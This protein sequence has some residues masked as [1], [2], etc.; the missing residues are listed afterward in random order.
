MPNSNPTVIGAIPNQTATED[1]FY[2]LNISGYFT[3]SDPGDSLTYSATGL[4][5]GLTINSTTGV[6]SGTPTNT[7]VGT[8]TITIFANDKN[9]GSTSTSFNLLVNNTNDA[10]TVVTAI[11]DQ[12]ATEDSV[13]SFN[14]STYFSDVDANDTL[15]YSATGLPDG[16][17]IN[18][19]SGVIS[20]TP[21]NDAVG[22]R[23]ISIT[24]T[25]TSGSKATTNFK[26][27]VANTND[28]PTATTIANRNAT[29]DTFFSMNVSSGFVDI[30][31]GDTLTY[32]AS[33][34]PDGLTIN[35][36]TGVISG[37]PTNNAVG[38]RN[39]TVT[40]TDSSGK[41]AS[42]SFYINIANT[43]DAPT[44]AEAIA[45]QTA[46]EDQSFSLNV[47]NN[48]A[49]MDIGDT[50]TFS[51]TGLPDGLSINT[52]TG[53]ISGSPTNAA[54][55]IRN[56]SVTATDISGS[57]VSTSFK[58]TVAN[59][60]DAPTVT[61]IANQNA[62]E[63]AFFSMN[64]SSYFADIDAGDTLT[65][66]ATGLP[67][68]V[69]INPT[70]GVISGNPTNASV[71]TRNVTVTATDTSGNNANSSFNIIVA[72][73]NDAPTVVAPIADQTA[74]EDAPFSL[75]TSLYF[76]DIDGIDTLT[77]S[78]T[79]LPSG[80][81]IDT[82]TGQISGNALNSAVGS[83]NVTVTINDG[84]GG[85]ASNT[86]KL[87][88]TNTNDAP[89]AASTLP[90][91]TAT[92]D[93][94]FSTNVSS[95]FSDPDVG[96]TLSFYATNLPKGLSINNAT[97]VI[98]GFPTNEAVGNTTVTIT[99]SDG[100]GGTVSNSFV[101]TVANT[102]DAPVV[103]LPIGDRS[104][105]E[106]SP[107]T[108]D[109]SSNFA[110]PDI[111][112]T[113]TYTATGLPGGLSIASATGIISGTPTNSSVGTTAV[114]VTANDGKGGT[115]S[116]AFNL[117]VVN[118]ND[119]PTLVSAI[120]DAS[121]TEDAPFIYSVSNHF[122]DPDVGDTLT[123]F[124]TGLPSGL[125]LDSATGL[126]SGAPT[127]AAVG[128]NTI[129]IIAS[130]SKGGMTSG[131]F[132]LTVANTNDGPVVAI[133]IGDRSTAEDATFTLDVS[134]AFSDPDAGDTLT[135]A[136]TGLPDGLAIN[137]STGIISGTPTNTAVGAN[138]ITVTANDGKGGSV[139]TS[140]TLTVTN[141]NDAPIL[142]VAIA[143]Q[144][145]TED[146][147][148]TYSVSSHFADIDQGDTLSFFAKGLPNGLTLDSVTGLISGTPTN[149]AV[150]THTISL[151]ASDSK[152][153]TATDSFDLVVANTND[154]PIVV[155][156][157]ADR[158]AIEDVA[159]NLN[160]SANFSDPDLGDT[161]TYS[162][163]GLPAG[164]TIDSTTGLISGTPNN[165]AVGANA[166][167]V[168]ASD[169]NGSTVNSDFTL[170]VTNVNDD[171]I[172]TTPLTNQSTVV[173]VPYSLNVSS[174]FGDLDM[175]NT[176]TYF[177]TG[178]PTGLSIDGDT[179]V[180]SGN[181]ANV[182]TSSITITANDGNGGTI[183]AVFDLTVASNTAPTV[184]VAIADQT[185][186]AQASYSL[187]LNSGTFKEVDPGDA[188][189]L[190]ASL[191][192]GNGLPGWLSFNPGTRTFSGIP[193]VGDVG[194]LGIRVTATDR[195]GV[196]VSDVFNLTVN[197]PPT[198]STPTTPTPAIPSTPGI[199]NPGTPG[200]PSGKT[201]TGTKK[202]DRLLGSSGDDVLIGLAGNDSLLAQEGNDMVYGGGGNDYINGGTGVDTLFGGVGNDKLKG[203]L[204]RDIFVL[205]KGNGKDTFVDFN[206]KSDRLGLSRGLSFK[207]LT[208]TQSGRFASISLGADQIAF[209]EGVQAN[210]LTAA[211][212]VKV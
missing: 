70:T 208:I 128:V 88:V 43:N 68:G 61:S 150:G 108:L 171:P 73:T 122:A 90:N 31:A 207:A 1:V 205:E 89:T 46:T 39:V 141:V 76:T 206:R 178:L 56:V 211:S 180:I 168:T 10:P 196:A 98:S 6:V 164:L 154:A 126:I 155:N 100:N 51:A 12:A 55:G 37:T 212:F 96:D 36:T 192:N 187:T 144:A 125:S 204:D 195:S 44:V 191:D 19:S 172:V 57:K 34:L 84:K 200:L 109:V 111:G 188:L 118:T 170:T 7:A 117:T 32:S 146:I 102:N 194:N 18:A 26:L 82:N 81:T 78:A 161:L 62:T 198:G 183:D 179:G 132:K 95:F 94:F 71:G 79:G 149:A 42:T 131:S 104:A 134:S 48:F 143:D 27:I 50:L 75:N 135:Y 16:L 169:G 97:G 107:F 9:G 113:L 174:H 103:V 162:A 29:E 47:K 65:Y 106:D 91:R 28:A 167:T 159:F 173:N 123:F 4:P 63:D 2:G 166:V 175:G 202:G 45:D 177:A 151:T 80:L 197:A 74:V 25:D 86:F 165:A 160:V 41:T 64:V 22:T 199:S 23:N 105:Q 184:E 136:A 189:T 153:G 133:P 110:D 92:E 139:S 210:Q 182:G 129:T 53:V 142:N 3:D 101:L 99:A 115:I 87:T 69:T 114:V 157:I 121:A 83:R 54:V 72:N 186:T 17:S 11:A 130:D 67:D 116:N 60:N 13:F 138:S 20:G 201:I 52:N 209:L 193:G 38:L 85:T 58:L 14:V 145:A 77:Y 40:A 137:S 181:P 33:E 59:V 140:F 21:T 148:F 35:G 163:T 158:T 127:N 152:G 93:A 156:A 112:N 120:A 24:A 15:T 119:E 30:D 124:A 66:G 49:D 147:P 5:D 185:T 190:T 203:G 8:R 176:L